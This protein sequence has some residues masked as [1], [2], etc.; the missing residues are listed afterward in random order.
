M[1][2]NSVSF[3]VLL[4]G[5]LAVCYMWLI[6]AGNGFVVGY[7]SFHC[8]CF[9]DLIRDIN[10]LP[11]ELK[12]LIEKLFR[13][14]LTPHCSSIIHTIILRVMKSLSYQDLPPLIHQL[15]V[16]SC[17]G[18]VP[19]ILEGILNLFNEFGKEEEEESE[20]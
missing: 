3:Q 2:R 13:F 19:L 5:H 15:L 18:H 12:F 7:L 11:E 4:G 9:I 1:E 10:L 6:C 20:E 17:K 16:I 14:I 8:F